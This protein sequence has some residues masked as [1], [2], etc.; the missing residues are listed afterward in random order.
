MTK[1]GSDRAV[2]FLSGPTEATHHEIGPVDRWKLLLQSRIHS[3]SGNRL[4]RNV[5]PSRMWGRCRV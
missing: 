4:D 5:R 2:E 3:T 1:Y